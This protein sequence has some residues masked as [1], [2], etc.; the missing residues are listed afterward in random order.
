MVDCL[1]RGRKPRGVGRTL[2]V[3]AAKRDE[4]YS[5]GRRIKANSPKQLETHE[6]D[7]DFLEAT[8]LN[9]SGLQFVRRLDSKRVVLIADT[10]RAGGFSVQ[11][12]GSIGRSLNDMISRF[13]ESEG[14][15]ILTSS[16]WDE[17]SV[18]PPEMQNGVFT[19]YLLKGLKGEAD[20]NNDG[21]VSLQ[22]VYEYVY[23]KTKEYTSGKQHP[24]LE[25]KVQGVF[26]ISLTSL[27]PTRVSRPERPAAL[28]APSTSAPAPADKPSDVERLRA[29]AEAGDAEAQFK[30]GGLYE[31][32][33]GVARDTVAAL[34]W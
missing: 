8:A 16:R 32:G 24:Q 28:P 4:A 7:P 2:Y 11:G 21:V 5:R 3:R 19:H 23:S 27:Y 10:C 25:G 33:F 12:A 22:E 6:A 29:Q 14:K 15:V 20:L 34:A 1:C 31:I 17:L 9:M 30:L 13:T 18:E 26:P